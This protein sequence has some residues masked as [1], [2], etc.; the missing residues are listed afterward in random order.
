MRADG[1]AS[2]G[3][4]TRC[5]AGWQG[6]LRSG[7]IPRC[8]S[9][10]CTRC[11]R[12]PSP[13]PRSTRSSRR[14]TSRSPRSA[15]RSTTRRS[16]RPSW[17]PTARQ[18]R[19]G[20]RH[21]GRRPG[22]LLHRRPVLEPLQRLRRRH[23]PQQ[24]GDNGYGLVRPV[25]FTARDGATISGHVWATVAG[26]GQAAGDRD[27][28][29]LGPGRRADVLVRRPDAGQGRLRRAH[30]RSPG[31]GPVRHLR[32]VARPERG[33]PRPDRR[34]PFYDGTEDAIDFLLSTPQPSLRAGAELQHR[35]QP[36]RQAELPR[37]GR[38][39]RAYNPFWQLFDPRRDRSGRPLLRRRRRV[40][41][42]PVGSARQGRGRLDNLG[43][44]GP[45]R[46]RRSRRARALQQ[47]IGEQGCPADPA[48]RTTVP[49]TKPA[50]GSR[51]T[52]ACRRRPTPRCPTRRQGA[53]VAGLHARPAST[54][55]RSS[56]AAARTWT[57]ASSPTRPSAPRCAD[58]T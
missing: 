45:G 37:Q 7:L 28:Q 12:R 5:S 36:R 33:R 52:T 56:S 42:R 15:R 13:P 54:A 24:L 29:R 6:R 23:P 34:T 38:A 43:G 53:G 21:R 14:R 1:L 2:P 40:L 51:P 50:S 16:T 30:L 32:P 19:P 20:A 35:H 10:R 55:A 9:S 49:I 11:P 3:R 27:H 25:L 44:P 58:P 31:P 39:R 4:R 22:A 26:P 57:S 8:S 46:R 48:D 41:H 47:T 17:R 18:H